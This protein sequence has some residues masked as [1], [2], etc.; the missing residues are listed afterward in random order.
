MK[1]EDISAR[2]SA[3]SNASSSIRESGGFEARVTPAPFLND[4][5]RVGE[6]SSGD[7]Q[8]QMNAHLIRM[9][10]MSSFHG[11]NPFSGSI[12]Q[13]ALEDAFLD[14]AG[15]RLDASNVLLSSRMSATP[16]TQSQLRLKQVQM[17]AQSAQDAT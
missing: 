4:V 7:L 16:E 1:E 3:A 10:T 12:T 17:D 14:M 6:E 11:D 2:Q 5:Y 15:S 9:S 8:R 13:S